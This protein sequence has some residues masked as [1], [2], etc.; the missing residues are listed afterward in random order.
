LSD[1]ELSTQNQCERARLAV[2][3]VESIMRRRT[4]PRQGGNLSDLGWP[5]A[6]S[7]RFRTANPA[8]RWLPIACRNDHFRVLAQ[9]E[10]NVIARMGAM[11]G[12]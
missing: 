3:I 5:T 11:A 12:I 2:L 4:R 6:P 10:I 9:S 8:S 7:E 1:I